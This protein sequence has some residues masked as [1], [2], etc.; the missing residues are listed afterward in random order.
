MAQMASDVLLEELLFFLG[1]EGVVSPT[2]HLRVYR[3]RT[4]S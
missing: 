4:D 3:V 1:A 2:V